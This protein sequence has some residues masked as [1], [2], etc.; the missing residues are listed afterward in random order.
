MLLI[1]KNKKNKKFKL[2]NFS[3]IKFFELYVS[4]ECK[5]IINLLNETL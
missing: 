2:Q 5:M 1:K 3:N 4:N